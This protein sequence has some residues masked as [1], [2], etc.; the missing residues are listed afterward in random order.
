MDA[1]TVFQNT[2]LARRVARRFLAMDFP[3]EKALKTYL[4][5]HP[6]AD[7][8]KH[9]VKEKAQEKSQSGSLKG[10]NFS[11]PLPKGDRKSQVKQLS[12]SLSEREIDSAMEVVEHRIR[13][14]EAGKFHGSQRGDWDKTEQ[15]QL[16]AFE[17]TL[18]ILSSAKRRKADAGYDEEETSRE[19]SA[20][21]KKTQETA[22]ATEIK[23]GVIKGK[24]H[25]E[26]TAEAIDKAWE[27][28]RHK[29]LAAIAKDFADNNSVEVLE[30]EM[31]KVKKVLKTE[32]KT[33][34]YDEQTN[35]V[36]GLWETLM[37][38]LDKKRG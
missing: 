32:E 16:D 31:A 1:L 18:G 6:D 33:R 11:K 27:K 25:K 28:S 5:E 14:L 24:L 19:E 13:K 34:D 21:K 36:N 20:K 38:A 37:A 3:S 30:S 29:G 10:H 8:S 22:T 17:K 9:H 12:D 2:L 4:R 26:L 23:K 35:A 7:R 15:A